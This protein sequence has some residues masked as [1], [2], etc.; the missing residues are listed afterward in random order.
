MSWVSVTRSYV[1]VGWGS[2][3]VVAV[4]LSFVVSL[5]EIVAV[6]LFFVVSM[7]EI[8][9]VSVFFWESF[10]TVAVSVFFV[11]LLIE[12]SIS[13]SS[14]RILELPREFRDFWHSALA[15]AV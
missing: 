4:S 1:V 13:R 10:E 11:S 12:C 15:F 2:F 7:A 3:E 9:V 6:S 14:S 5:V 8:V